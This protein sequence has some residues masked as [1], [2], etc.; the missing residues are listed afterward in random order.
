MEGAF[1]ALLDE[2]RVTVVEACTEVIAILQE[3]R[4]SRRIES[5]DQ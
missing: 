5:A 2:S 3:L 4:Q 1:R